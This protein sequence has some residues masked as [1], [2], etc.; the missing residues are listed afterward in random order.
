MPAGK[1][2]PRIGALVTNGDIGYQSEQ[3]RFFRDI[4]TRMSE[5]YPDITFRYD[6]GRMD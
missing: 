5:R 6:A 1:R 2:K 3:E 4:I